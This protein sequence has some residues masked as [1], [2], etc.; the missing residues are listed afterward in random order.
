[1]ARDFKPGKY[2]V[3]VLNIQPVQSQNGRYQTSLYCDIRGIFD[4]HT[5]EVVACETGNC[6]VYVD[7]QD[8]DGK[9]IVGL[10]CKQFN[11][12]FGCEINGPDDLHGDNPLTVVGAIITVNLTHY[13]AKAGKYAGE[14]C[15]SWKLPNASGSQ[16]AANY[17]DMRKALGLNIKK[18]TKNGNGKKPAG[19]TADKEIPF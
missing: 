13:V 11:K 18:P 6:T 4:P 16:Q 10:V 12:A 8:K 17:A 2:Q 7:W 15:E 14:T 3:E 9:E 1:M 5:N 19:A